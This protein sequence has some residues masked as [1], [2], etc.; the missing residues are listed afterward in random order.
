MASLNSIDENDASLLM[1]IIKK[2]CNNRKVGFWFDNAVDGCNDED[3]SCSDNDDL[4][5]FLIID[6]SSIIHWS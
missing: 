5:F 6:P 2:N 3:D 1:H 4:I